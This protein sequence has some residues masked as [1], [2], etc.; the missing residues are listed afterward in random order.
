MRKRFKVEIELTERDVVI[1]KMLV[2]D[3]GA[4]AIHNRLHISR[5]RLI[6]IL[7]GMYAKLG[8][9]GK[10]QAAVWAVRNKVV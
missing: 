9:N 2:E 4:K 6:D 3:I 5:S 10:T 7:G 1:L 8:V